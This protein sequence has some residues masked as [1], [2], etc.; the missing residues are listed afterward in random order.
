MKA[1]RLLATGLLAVALMTLA[2]CGQ[3]A[4]TN[5]QTLVSSD[6]GRTWR[7]IPVGSSIP[8]AYLACDLRVSIPNYPMQ[9]D[10]QF[11]VNF[12]NRVLVTN[13]A[14]Y[15][16][17]I[18]DPMKFIT[19]ARYVGRQNSAADG[20][21]NSATAYE[22]AE[23]LLIDRRIREV[24]SALLREEDIV[25]FDSTVFEDRLLIEVN[26]VLESRGVVLNS[27]AFV[28]VPDV[29]T[30]Q[31]IDAGAAI[32][33]YEAIGLGELGRQMMIARAGASTVTV[34]TEKPE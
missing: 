17:T 8:R 22:T 11:K 10:A 21:D 28:P 31:A 6:C 2:A 19:N 9:G 7:L 16:Y 12:K 3:R 5:M 24:A 20:G 34:T 1:L 32:R 30:R 26:K 15:E 4:V 27:V 23:N 29:Q 14:S 18:T 25:V 33:V 13:S